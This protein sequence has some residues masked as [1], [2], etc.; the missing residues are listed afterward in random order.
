[1]CIE[2]EGDLLVRQ[3]SRLREP[4]AFFVGRNLGKPCMSLY[5]E[6]SSF[7]GRVSVCVSCKAAAVAI[8][9]DIDCDPLSLR[10]QVR[11]QSQQQH[12]QCWN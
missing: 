10:R 11:A 1:M 7:I 3:V 5:L 2:R 9:A 6:I 4:Y 12:T 8:H